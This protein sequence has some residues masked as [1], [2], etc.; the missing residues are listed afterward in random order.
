MKTIKLLISC[1]FLSIISASFGQSIEVYVSDAGN[2]NF[3][4]WQILKFDENGENPS[5]FISDSLVWPQDILFLEDQ[6]VVLI[7]N[8]TTPGYISRHDINTGDFINYFAENISGPTRMKIGTD[9]LLYVLQ[10]SSTDNKVLRYELDGTF[11]D[12]FTSVG[13]SQSIGLDWDDAGNLYVSSYGGK[14]IQK[15]DPDGNDLGPFINSNLTGPTNIWFVDNGDL[16]VNDYNS[17]KV[18]QFNSEGVYL[19]VYISGL[20]YPEGVDF[21]ENGNMLI[22]NGGTGSVKLFDTQ[23]NF[24]EDFIPSGSGDLLLPNAVIIRP[25][26]AVSVPLNLY[27][28]NFVS[29]ASGRM[30]SI[31]PRLT[32]KLITITIYNT[33]GKV[34]DK[35]ENTGY[36]TWNANNIPNG[37]YFVVAKDDKG[38]SSCQKILVKE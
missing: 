10:W 24:I 32:S 33:S 23:G 35:Q 11:V 8:L 2:Y 4:P 27:E 37:V 21:F 19:G 13:V 7:S 5:V 6:D 29:P 34:M 38:N 15:F 30:F 14:F 28:D 22:G 9:N 16:L 31:H 36:G 1:F 25:I 18:K 20:F 26:T 17:G 3:P 12:E